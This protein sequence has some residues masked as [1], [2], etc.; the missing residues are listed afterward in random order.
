[1]TGID[2]PWA[3]HGALP[4]QLAR[5][6]EVERLVRMGIVKFLNGFPQAGMPELSCRTHSRTAAARHAFAH[7]RL[8]C[9]QLFEL[10]LSNKSRLILE[11]GTRPKPKST[12]FPEAMSY[13]F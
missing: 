8:D 5:L 3:N 13:S 1:M 12:I 9:R 6:Q 10:S 7:I 2:A 4:A 11:L